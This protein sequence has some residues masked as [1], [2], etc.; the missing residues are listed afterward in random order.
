MK[1]RIY[2][3]KEKQYLMIAVA[4][5]LPLG[6]IYFLFSSKWMGGDIIENPI[7]VIAVLFLVGLEFWFL[8][9]GVWSKELI[10]DKEKKII[11]IKTSCPFVFKPTIIPFQEVR[12]VWVSSRNNTGGS[13]RIYNLCIDTISCKKIGLGCFSDND[14]E[15]HEKWRDELAEFIGLKNITKLSI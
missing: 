11:T 6:L 2:S 7:Q 9:W 5:W 12:K 8:G 13:D 4:I 3:I 1:N 15:K 10:A 14:R